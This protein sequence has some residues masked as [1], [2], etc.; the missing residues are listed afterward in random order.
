VGCEYGDIET[1][2]VK[3]KK[4]SSISVSKPEVVVD[5]G[6]L[7]HFKLIGNS[8]REVTI[9]GESTR[10]DWLD[11]TSPGDSKDKDRDI[12]ICVEESKISD[13]PYMYELI[14]DKVGRLDP[15]VRVR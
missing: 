15:A 2:K 8:A 11:R 5:A 10:G 13:D 14:V 3:F 1:V 4:N 9:E 6:N 12:Y 7:L